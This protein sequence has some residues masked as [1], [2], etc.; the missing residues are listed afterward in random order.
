MRFFDCPK[1]APEISRTSKKRE[2][3]VEDDEDVDVVEIINIIEYLV[4]LSCRNIHSLYFH[5]R[6]KDV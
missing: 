5:S 4:S 3:H 1:K 2:E 6:I